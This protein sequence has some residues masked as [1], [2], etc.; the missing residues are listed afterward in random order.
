MFVEL[1]F[2]RKPDTICA[3][4]TKAAM[5]D[6]GVAWLMEVVFASVGAGRNRNR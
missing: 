4:A 1:P 5:K 2:A 3:I 6:A